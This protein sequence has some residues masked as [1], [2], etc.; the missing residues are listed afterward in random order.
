M[1]MI[2]NDSLRPCE[3]QARCSYR[4]HQF[5][6]R[7]N[8][9]TPN[10]NLSTKSNVNITLKFEGFGDFV[11]SSPVFEILRFRDNL[12]FNETF[13]SLSLVGMGN[14]SQNWPPGISAGASAR[15]ATYCRR[16]R[17]HEIPL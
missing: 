9:G 11:I 12:L 7:G 14:G 5:S 16:E 15:G 3:H 1:T 6:P 8:C 13:L 17:P 10:P 4:G 2:M